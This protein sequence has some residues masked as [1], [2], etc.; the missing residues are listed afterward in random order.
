VQDDGAISLFA[1]HKRILTAAEV[2]IPDSPA[3]ASR[4]GMGHNHF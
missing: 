3:L 4:R 2:E 1:R